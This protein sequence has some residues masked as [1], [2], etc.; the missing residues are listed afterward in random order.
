MPRASHAAVAP[1]A[2][3]CHHRAVKVV[4]LA[5]VLAACGADRTPAPPVAAASR[6]AAPA[7]TRVVRDGR[8]RPRSP[9]IHRLAWLGRDRLA[10][11]VGEGDPSRYVDPS[12]RS[13][14]LVYDVG[15][16]Y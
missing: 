4:A 12:G 6:P 8:V 13:A 10:V 16:A 11:L 15:H 2:P 9:W 5:V 1:H 7:C 3:A 14:V